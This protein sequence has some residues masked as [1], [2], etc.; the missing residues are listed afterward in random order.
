M[1]NREGTSL[2][3]DFLLQCE[4]D[5]VLRTG[6]TLHLRP[7]RPADEKDLLELFRHLSPDS[8]HFRFFDARSPE[9]ALAATPAVVDYD[10]DFGLVGELAGRVEAVVHYFRS[11]RHPEQAEVAFTVS[12]RLQGCGVGTR[13]LEALADIA[14]RRGIRTFVA[15]VLGANTK[16]MDVFLD[17]G[18]TATQ[19]SDSGSVRVSLSLEQTAAFEEKSA[20]RSIQAARASMRSV[21]EPRSIAVV[22]ASR[23]PG[24]IGRELFGNLIRTGFQGKLYP[25]NPTTDEVEYI[26]AYRTVASIPGEVDLAIIITP[27][28]AVEGVIDDCIAKG[29]RSVVVIT[30]GFSETGAAGRQRE[31]RLVEKIRSAGMRMVGP[32]CMGVINTAPAVRMH[33]TFSRIYPPPGNV[34]MSTQSGA[35]GLAILDYA[36][37]LNIGF[38]TFI[39]VGNKADVSGNDLVQYWAED[40][41]TGVILLYLESFGNPKKFGVIARRVSRKKPIVAVKAGRSRSGARAASSHTGALTESDAI[42]GELFKQAGIIR[43][44]TLEEMFDVAAVLAHQPLPQGRRV[45][46]L[47]NAGGPGIL[48]ADACEARGLELAQLSDETTATLRGFLPSTAAVGNP[49]DMIAS[50]SAQDY[51][52]AMSA[53]LQDPSVDALLLIYIPVLPEDVKGIASAIRDAYAAGG[54]KPVVGTFMSALGVPPELAPIPCFPFPERAVG[55]LARAT[56]YAQWRR[57]PRGIVRTYDDVSRDQVRRIVEPALQGGGRWLDPV[58]GF[59]LLTAAGIPAAPTA[60]AVSTN[61]AVK[62]AEAMGFPVVVKAWGEAIL[63]KS[64][65]G[66]V[67]LSLR[68]ANAVMRACDELRQVFGE[69]LSGVVVQKMIPGGAEMVVGATLES[70]FGHVLAFGTGGTMV[71]LFADVTFKLHPIT[72]ADAA[73]MLE[74]VRGAK[75]LRGFR[76]S[77]RLDEGAVVDVLQRLSV[78]VEYAPEIQEMDVNPLKVLEQGTMAVDWRIR[79]GRAEAKRSRRVSY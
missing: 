22:G 19:K 64:D 37:Q 33:G 49:V 26:P 35:L 47:T 13:L 28:D 68:D 31:E 74:A 4:S 73:E 78:L 34:A 38:S 48:A 8:M 12:D 32:N 39:S 24:S 16:M 17:S 43:T 67:K 7:I 10:Q 36:R 18:F 3:E 51:H 79:V 60:I 59:R 41:N 71:E 25:V 57:K 66:G 2:L 52:R 15:E 55:A 23:R 77:P 62:A 50:A 20:D 56:N 30:A 53:L 63:H 11:R 69:G 61:E 40:P 27:A 21:F 65:Q 54:G 72:D 45:A 76:G 44:D 46:I 58:E 5:V 9:A 1:T 75:L 6:Q 70:T 14:R 42:V 29:V